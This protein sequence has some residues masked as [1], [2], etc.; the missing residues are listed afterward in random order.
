MRKIYLDFMIV[1]LSAL[2]FMPVDSLAQ[3]EKA[4]LK[5]SSE[6]TI[7]GSLIFSDEWPVEDISKAGIYS[8][9]NE[10]NFQL[11]PIKIGTT[12]CSKGGGTYGEGKYYSLE[13]KGDNKI[14]RVFNANTW[15][16][17]YSTTFALAASDL[18]YDPV[19]KKI[20]GCFVLDGMQTELGIIEPSTGAYTSVANIQMLCAMA[21]DKEGNL[22]GITNYSGIL[23]KVDKNTGEF[24]IIGPTLLSPMYVQSGTIDLKTGKFYWAASTVNGEAGL[25]EVNLETGVATSIVTFDNS[26]SFTGLYT[27]D[28]IP[29]NAPA[30][31]EDLTI[32][33]PNGNTNGHITFTMPSKTYSGAELSGEITYTLNINEEIK[34]DRAQAG[35]Q[36][37]LPYTLE[38]KL[39]LVTAMASN[40]AGNSPMTVI[41]QWIGK[42]TPKAVS[43]LTLNR[44]SNYDII[45]DWIPPTEGING[46]YIDISELKY[47][48]TRY[49][50]NIIVAKDYT[51]N[52]FKQKINATKPL[53]YWYVVTTYW[54]TTEGDEVSS[55]KVIIGPGYSLPYS[56]DF[57]SSSAFGLFTVI[58]ANNDGITWYYET[59]DGAP[60]YVK[61]NTEKAN[62]WLITPPIQITPQGYY[63]ISFKTW[64][65]YLYGE[66]IR[67]AMGTTP[68]LDGMNKELIPVST[69]MTNDPILMEAKFSVEEGGSYFFGFQ[70]FS[71]PNL[72]R[73][74]ID[75]IKIE[76]IALITAPTAVSDLTITAAEKGMCKTTISFITP[77][78]N[79]KGE[80][81]S[82]LTKVE[83]FREGNL[84]KTFENPNVKTKLTY[85]DAT[86]AK[87]FNTYKVIAYNDSGNGDDIS[88]EVY[89]GTD[90]PEIA[91]S[92][93][94][95]EKEDGIEIKWVAPKVGK[96]GGYIDPSTL[97]YKIIRSNWTTV[98]ENL[99]DPQFIDK[100]FEVKT[101]QRFVAYSIYAISSEGMGEAAESPIISVGK[102]YQIPFTESFSNSRSTY[103]EWISDNMG[104]ASNWG[105]LEAGI[106]KNRTLPQD[107]DGGMMG[108]FSF[109]SNDQSR[110]ISPKIRLD[111]TINPVLDFWVWHNECNKQLFIEISSENGAYTTV[112]TIDLHT[113]NDIWINYHIDL[114]AYKNSSHIQLGFRSYI[115][116]Q[117]EFL[118]IDNIKISDN[119]DHNLIALSIEGPKK[120]NVG[121]SKNVSVKLINAGKQ[122][123]SGYKVKVL[124]GENLLNSKKGEA[125]AS[126]ET[127]I[128]NV[129]I[130]P[131]IANLNGINCHAVIEY[132]SDENNLNNT[133]D[134][135]NID[136]IPPTYPTATNLNGTVEE[137][138]IRLTWNAPLSPTM[139]T[140]IVE[141]FEE[142]LAFTLTKVGDWTLID[143]DAFETGMFRD[144]NGRFFEYENSGSPMAYQ[145][146][147]TELANMTEASGW[148]AFSG[149]QLLMCAY[150]ISNEN[151]N[152]DWIISPELFPGGQTISIYARSLDKYYGLEDFSLLYSTTGKN[153]KDF[154]LLEKKK[155]ISE[156]W[157]EYTFILPSDAKYFAINA[158]NT[159]HALLLDE[160]SYIPANAVPE[161]LRLEGYNIYRDGIKL[162]SIPINSTYYID[163]T[164]EPKSVHTYKVTAMYDKGESNYS[165]EITI[166]MNPDGIKDTKTQ[167]LIYT[168]PGTIVVESM[169]NYEVTI[170]SLE[171][172]LLYKK[173]S[174]SNHLSIPIQKGSYLVKTGSKL[175]KVIVK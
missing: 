51:Q 138:S 71:E 157:T 131:S 48:I 11:T 75:D 40:E 63:K 5:T 58:D 114:A 19:S 91:T 94:L 144:V 79:M 136:I 127:T 129:E 64:G 27:S 121:D 37:T 38:N 170:Y 161:A 168:I 122:E 26:E 105:V 109:M 120:I 24:I 69:V 164:V 163:D 173:T 80:T 108:M 95:Q 68:D 1:L 4:S 33:F 32:D 9:P 175:T 115:D 132:D 153:I 147:N 3:G 97:K 96:N 54:N 46:G 119:L 39:Y 125:L 154:I 134:N 23:Y 145:I 73:L 152:D 104:G 165:N 70:A 21:F 160:I 146:I 87:G 137:K 74:F 12:L 47:K 124:Q 28:P 59:V 8:F 89:V 158:V 113:E 31:I 81:I 85:E 149:K 52:S 171:G 10:G 169:S 61:S 110:L 34:K 117:T 166:T 17:E 77:S 123:A 102:S 78:K 86:P 88:A 65:N 84:I 99:S 93:Q 90:I 143:N 135:I 20:Y 83:I 66:Q 44:T 55:N 49:P 101:G 15:M 43:N 150:P 141:S 151:S 7:Y 126:G 76:Q 6:T 116:N 18:A 42:D 107:N 106:D 67:V 133:T 25:Y 41:T 148:T 92:I 13:L 72:Y 2:L 111:N 172:K 100:T 128:I 130:T 22:Y 16:E 142:Y 162:N 45:L 30:K 14:Y 60:Q 57:S 36:V 139:P 82:Q 140:P 118:Y 174:N 35:S 103:M 29:D 112:K 50:D 62:D 53:K 156:E 98:A 155:E 56:E 159:R 167:E